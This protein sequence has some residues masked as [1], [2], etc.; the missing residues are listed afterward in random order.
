M[1]PLRPAANPWQPLYG[2]EIGPS[3]AERTRSAL[4]L[5]LLLVAL[6]TA[7]AAGIGIVALALLAAVGASVG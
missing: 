3:R 5:A 2:D 4:L 6:G 1:A 7:L